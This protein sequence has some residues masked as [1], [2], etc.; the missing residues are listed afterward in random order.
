M[1]NNKG[2]IKNNGQKLDCEGFLSDMEFWS[3]DLAEELAKVNDIAAYGLTD[4]HWDVIKYVKNYYREYGRGPEMV[5]VAKNCALSLKDMCNLFSCGL[6][7]GAYRL[8][9]LPRPPG[10]I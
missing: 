8:A 4:A 10:C 5:K 3:V 6:V 2:E 9:G 7:K 1:E